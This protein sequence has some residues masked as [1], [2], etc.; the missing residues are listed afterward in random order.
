[1]ASQNDDTSPKKYLSVLRPF[2]GQT[3]GEHLLVAAAGVLGWSATFLVALAILGGEPI[4]TADEAAAR[5]SRQLAGGLAS[6]V[7]GLYFGLATARGR[8]GPVLNVLYAP[9]SAAVGATGAPIVIVY[10][11][12]PAGVFSAPERAGSVLGGVGEL[13][14]FLPA[15]VATIAVVAFH[16]EYVASPAQRARLR[17][18][19]SDLPGIH[20]GPRP[21]EDWRRADGGFDAVDRTDD[22]DPARRTPSASER[23]EDPD[24]D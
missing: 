24:D 2:P 7:A 8:G 14:V 20:P 9:L 21:M 10:G 18:R 17:R 3:P 5:G 12:A 1:M 16:Y 11:V 4:A 6:V 22:G 15:V 23:S 13:A 19:F